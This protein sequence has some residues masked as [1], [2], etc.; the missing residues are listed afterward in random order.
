[1]RLSR[2]VDSEKGTVRCGQGWAALQGMHHSEI[3]PCL[4][5]LGSQHRQ[6]LAAKPDSK[7]T[8]GH[9]P[10]LLVLNRLSEARS[11]AIASLPHFSLAS[12]NQHGDVRIDL[13][14]STLVCGCQDLWVQL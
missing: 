7:G 3:Q 12:E 11:F 13:Q 8:A 10:V 2:D 6:G 14:G 4:S 9:P 1:M 5:V